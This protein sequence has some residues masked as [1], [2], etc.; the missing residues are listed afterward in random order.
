MVSRDSDLK[1]LDN[2]IK[3][4]EKATAELMALSK[5]NPSVYKNAKRIMATVNILKI[6]VSD[7][8]DFKV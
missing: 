7:L 1:E 4:I 3:L 6:E 5:D 8:L 2:R